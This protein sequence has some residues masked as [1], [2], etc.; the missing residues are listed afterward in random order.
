MCAESLGHWDA[1]PLHGG[2]FGFKSGPRKD[3]GG[4]SFLLCLATLS[5]A[6]RAEYVGSC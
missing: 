3:A 2:G 5:G 4:T 6:W 1:C